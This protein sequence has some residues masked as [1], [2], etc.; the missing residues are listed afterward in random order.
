M[1]TKIKSTLEE[2][3]LTE[4]VESVGDDFDELDGDGNEGDV[5]DAK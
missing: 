4:Y 5:P 3:D 1:P 2:Y